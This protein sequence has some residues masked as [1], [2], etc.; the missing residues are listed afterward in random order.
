MAESLGSAKNG[1]NFH[2]SWSQI[3]NLADPDY[4]TAQVLAPRVY[5]QRTRAQ[6]QGK[7]G[8]WMFIFPD[9]KNTGNFSKNIENLFLLREFTSNTG[10]NLKFKKLKIFP[11]CGVMYQCSFEFCCK[12]WYLVNWEMEWDYCDCSLEGVIS[13]I[14]LW[15]SSGIN[16]I[17]MPK[18]REKV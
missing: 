2:P 10:E 3:N 13:S 14:F 4:S 5:V 17:L 18:H 9:R 8:I 7:P 16:V 12:F 11:D 1:E 6:A 15:D